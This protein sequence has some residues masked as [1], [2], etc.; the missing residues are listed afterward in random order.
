MMSPVYQVKKVFFG[1]FDL[2]AVGGADQNITGFVRMGGHLPP[3]RVKGICGVVQAN[4][5]RTE[6]FFGQDALLFYGNRIEL[7]SNYNCNPPFSSAELAGYADRPYVNKTSVKFKRG[8]KFYAIP[9]GEMKL[10]SG[11]LEMIRKLIEH[12]RVNLPAWMVD[13]VRVE[14]EWGSHGFMRAFGHVFS[15]FPQ[16]LREAALE[17]GW[18]YKL[19]NWGEARIRGKVIVETVYLPKPRII[20]TP[21]GGLPDWARAYMHRR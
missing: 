20:Y 17:A 2:K 3:N 18:F 13:L 9:V 8:D 19:K 6:V 7:A 10:S 1:N 12:V 15:S 21:L 4:L 16:G 14:I 5:E 11:R